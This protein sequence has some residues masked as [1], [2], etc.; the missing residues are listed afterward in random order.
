MYNLVITMAANAAEATNSS[1]NYAQMATTFRIV[2]IV[3]FCLA[4]ACLAF[5]IFCF[6]RFKIPKIIGD[7]SG[8]TAKKSIEQ[9][10]AENE[11]SGN[12]SYRPHPVA[13]SRGTVTEPIKQSG[14]LKKQKAQKQPVSK[15]AESSPPNNTG[16]GATDVLDD[17]NATEPLNYN[18]G[19]TEILGEGT[20]V[21]SGD[22]IQVALNQS[23]TKL[24][25]IQNIVFIHTEEVI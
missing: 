4:G 7:L 12:K 9:M 25:M 19:G 23:E 8:R 6:F 15:K 14:R 11:K 10:R 3:M 21:L 16:S 5:G 22:E 2:S 18:E 17:L 20:Q 1:T 24:K 13:Q